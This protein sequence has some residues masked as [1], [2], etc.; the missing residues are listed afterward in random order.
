MCS[1]QWLIFLDRL[2]AVPREFAS[3]FLSL[4][5]SSFN[6]RSEINMTD[7]VTHPT[8]FYLFFSIPETKH[9]F[10]FTPNIVIAVLGVNSLKT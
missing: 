6:R 10:F 7:R 9:Y 3:I 8:V 4:F 5:L 1:S 2:L